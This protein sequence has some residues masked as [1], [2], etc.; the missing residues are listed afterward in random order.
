MRPKV[1][2]YTATF[3]DYDVVRSPVVRD[4][5]VEYVCFTDRRPPL[6]KGWTVRMVAPPPVQPYT[7]R[8]YKILSHQV[9]PEADITLYHDGNFQ[10]LVSPLDLVGAYLKSS[11]IAFFSHPQRNS[12]YDEIDACAQ[13]DKDNEYLL[14]LLASRYRSLGVP[15]EGHL[16]AGGVI[17]RRHTQSIAEF[18][19]AWMSELRRSS[20]RD[21]PALAFTLWNE[22]IEPASINKNIWKNELIRYHPHKWRN[23]RPNRNFLFVCGNPRSGTSALCDLLNVDR[24]IIVGMERYRRIRQMVTPSH[25]TKERFVDPSPGQTNYLPRRL[26]PSNEPGFRVWPEDEGELVDKWDSAELRYVG[27]KAPFYV[28]QL[29]YMREVFPGAR[30]VVLLRDPVGVA[31]SYQRRAT[32][33]NDH[34]PRE[35]DFSVGLEHW[36]QTIDDILSDIH[37]HGLRQVFIVHYE[38]FFS[39]DTS[40]L[41]SLY[42]FLEL[43][44]PNSVAEVYREMTSGWSGRASESTVLSDFQ[45]QKVRDTANWSGYDQ[46]S[47]T[48]PIMRHYHLLLG[49]GSESKGS[50]RSQA[51]TAAYQELFDL[52]RLLNWRSMQASSGG[53]AHGISSCSKADQS[54]DEAWQAFWQGFPILAAELLVDSIAAEKKTSGECWFDA[55]VNMLTVDPLAKGGEAELAVR[56]ADTQAVLDR[57]RS[58]RSVRLA[59]RVS[60]LA[61]PLFKWWRLMARHESS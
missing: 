59:L 54:A 15:E 43:D 3:G 19:E 24:R 55:L 30:F 21:Q 7:Q 60:R 27:D 4:E 56:L 33:P 50:A 18:N 14:K 42:Q 16:F 25:F 23:V 40:Y 61:Q 2:V 37:G 9:F 48:I 35:N 32:D 51:L 31:N 5:G 39:G 1:V 53:T 22:A 28:R 41:R 6:A 11:D 29:P 17:L 45:M 49:A 52:S 20:V 38:D 44:L 12:V 26:I 8:E 13:L 47:Q 10:L 58:R 57:L 36:N 46:L 34:W